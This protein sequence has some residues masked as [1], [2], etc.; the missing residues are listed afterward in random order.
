MF[1]IISKKRRNVITKDG[2]KLGVRKIYQVNKFEFEHKLNPGVILYIKT[3]EELMLYKDDVVW[4]IGCVSNEGV[5]FITFSFNLFVHDSPLSLKQAIYL[6][7]NYHEEYN[8][9]KY[10]LLKS[11]DETLYIP[12][13]D[14]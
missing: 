12:K 9:K 5:Y 11:T 14:F 13:I 4:Y 6:L 8:H 1:K 3:I 2:N 7:N 10:I